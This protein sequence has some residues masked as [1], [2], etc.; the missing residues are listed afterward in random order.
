[1]SAIFFAVHK[2]DPSSPRS[3]ECTGRFVFPPARGASVP[4]RVQHHVVNALMRADCSA[5]GFSL[6]YYLAR[7]FPYPFCMALFQIRP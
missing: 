2:E 4:Q 1:M 7:E 5:V 3:S 6:T